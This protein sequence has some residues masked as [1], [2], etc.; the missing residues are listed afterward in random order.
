MPTSDQAAGKMRARSRPWRSTK[1]LLNPGDLHFGKQDMV[2]ADGYRSQLVCSVRGV[3]AVGEPI[4]RARVFVVEEQTLVDRHRS[5]VAAVTGEMCRESAALVIKALR[6]LRQ[7]GAGLVVDLSRITFIDG[8]GVSALVEEWWDHQAENSDFV[9]VE[10]SRV[11]A[12]VLRALDLEYLLAAG[13]PGNPDE[14]P[15]TPDQL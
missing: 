1:A 7:P 3:N 2:V 13:P 9:I 10:P 4:T 14:G 11:V 12:R 8:S 5:P 6:D 15:S